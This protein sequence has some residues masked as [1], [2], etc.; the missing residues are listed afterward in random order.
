MIQASSFLVCFDK[1]S[2]FSRDE[3]AHECWH[4]YGKNRWFDKSMQF[5]VFSNGKAGFL[6]EHSMFDATTPAHV[7]NYIQDCAKK[8][9]NPDQPITSNCELPLPKPLVLSS[10]DLLSLTLNTVTENLE[11][12]I[13]CREIQ[14]C[15]YYRFGK[16]F[17]KSHKMSPDSF[18]QMA[19]Q[20]AYFR[21]MHVCCATYESVGM[22]KFQWG[23]TETCRSVSSDSVEFCNAMDN[24][25]LS[26]EEK[27]QYIREAVETHSNYMAECSMGNG[28]D[29]HLLGLRLCLKDTEVMPDFFLDPAYNLSCHWTLSTSQI[30]SDHFEGYG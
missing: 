11:K 24:P 13:N 16:G 26:L 10:N 4:G 7:C 28:V 14:A 25:D 17:I 12:E 8:Y 9:L 15:N 30:P 5:I 29:R 2:P 22:K 23:R 3:I 21:L 27:A 20:Y 18:V 19:I 6:G 1:V